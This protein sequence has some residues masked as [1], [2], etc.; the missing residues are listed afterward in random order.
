MNRQVTVF[1]LIFAGIMNHGF[2]QIIPSESLFDEG[3]KFSLGDIR[4]AEQPGFDDA[5]WRDIDL[6]HDWSIENLPLQEVQPVPELP[7][8]TGPWRFQKGDDAAW[9]AAGF[10]DSGWQGVTLPDTWERHSDYTGNNVYGWYRRHID[11]PAACRNR[12]FDLLL[13]CIDDV[14]EAFFN[15]ER[16]GG[17]G[18]FPPAYRTAYNTQRRYRIPA[19]LVRGDGSDV[20]AVR[21]FDGAGDGGI[22]AAGTKSMRLGPFDSGLS[23]GGTATGYAVGGTGWYRKHFT[24]PYSSYPQKVSICFD[25]VYMN[26]DVWL[27]GRHL[28]NH[29]YGYT[30]FVLDLTP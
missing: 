22:F 17:T 14:D 28:G 5:A 12:D 15:G 16:V 18:S 4:E 23:A 27:N 20:L 13:G 25:G 9:K 24:L 3:W 29:P 21:V 11:I 2:A 19:S 30:S 7:A 26:A 6:P 10:D 1:L 8:V